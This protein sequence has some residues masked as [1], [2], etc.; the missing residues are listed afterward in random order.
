MNSI[1][2]NDWIEVDQSHLDHLLSDKRLNWKKMAE[3]DFYVLVHNGFAFA[4]RDV[5]GRIFVHPHYDRHPH[6]LPVDQL[7][8]V[9]WD[10]TKRTRPI[11]Y[12]DVY[13]RI[14][15]YMECVDPNACEV[16]AVKR[17]IKRHG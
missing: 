8:N 1:I 17:G 7:E 13:C 2:P 3:T 14:C 12:F 6:C 10:Q 16:E 4:G 5:K 9:F 11:K 15:R